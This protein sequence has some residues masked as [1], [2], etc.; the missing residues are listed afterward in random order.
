MNTPA[1]D[2]CPCG[3]CGKPTP[4]TATKRC[5]GCWELERRIRANPELAQRILAVQEPVKYSGWVWQHVS[6]G[7]EYYLLGDARM[8][9][10]KPVADM[11]EV[12]VY[13]GSD[14]RIWVRPVSE[15]DA[16]FKRLRVNVTGQAS[17]TIWDGAH[18]PDFSKV[19]K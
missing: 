17:D 1:Y 8:Q 6:S 16:R 15:F 11:A 18:A 12:Y 13:Q 10:D 3:L 7:G 9:T 4:M 19:P 14:N 5:D 2:T